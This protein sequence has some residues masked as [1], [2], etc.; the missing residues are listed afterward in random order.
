MGIDG[1]KATAA[2]VCHLDTSAWNPKQFA[3]QVLKVK[4]GG[5]PICHFLNIDT[6]VWVPY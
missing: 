5:P 6:I 2:V 4:P 3:F 1:S